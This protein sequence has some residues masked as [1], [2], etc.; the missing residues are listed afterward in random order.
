M[1]KVFDYPVRWREAVNQ[2][3]LLQQGNKSVSDF[4]SSFRILARET[5][6]DQ[7]VLQGIFLRL[8]EELK[9]ELAVRDTTLSLYPLINLAS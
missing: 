3:L 1:L 6:R 9:D 4:S 5:G 2:L 7:A 8:S